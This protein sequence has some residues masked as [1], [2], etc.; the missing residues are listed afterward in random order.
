MESNVE[1]TKLDV[2]KAIAEL[3]QRHPVPQKRHGQL[4]LSS[5]YP[6]AG[7]HPVR[8]QAPGGGSQGGYG[9]AEP[10]IKKTRKIP[11]KS[12]KNFGQNCGG[13]SQAVIVISTAANPLKEQM[14]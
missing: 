3:G 7:R 5:R 6:R 11:K 9:Q 10:A 13:Q 2:V 12:E 4:L 1:D 8:D 14:T